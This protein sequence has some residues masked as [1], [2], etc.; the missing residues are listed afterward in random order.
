VETAFGRYATSK[1]TRVEDLDGIATLG[2]RGEALASIAAVAQVDLTTGI[3][4]APSAI[5]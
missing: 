4:E 2:F 5:R 3:K 1:I